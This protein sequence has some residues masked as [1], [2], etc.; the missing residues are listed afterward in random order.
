[1]VNKSNSLNFDSYSPT[2][3]TRYGHEASIFLKSVTKKFPYLIGIIVGLISL[4]VLDLS[5]DMGLKLIIGDKSIDTL[6][7]ILSVS[8]LVIL[9][10][11]VKPLFKF[12]H[13]LERWADLFEK[14]SLTAEVEMMISNRNKDEVLSSVSSVLEP[15]NSPLQRYLEARTT[16]D[17]FFNVDFSGYVFNILIDNTTIKNDKELAHS[18]QEYGA[19]IINIYDELVDI[20]KFNSF[21][22]A[23]TRYSSRNN[24]GLALIVS[25]QI[26]SEVYD[27]IRAS[28]DKITRK[29]ILV[30]K[31][32]LDIT[33]SNTF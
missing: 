16:H 32:T 25:E 8:M 19:I 21:K 13:V 28:T 27:L 7:I 18:I 14:N 2:M 17:E 1:M 24:V 5:A 11:V 33:S 15:V 31:P 12:Q 22:N 3:T 4:T 10:I 30:E 23:V 29:I 6:I 20:K 9:I 26:S